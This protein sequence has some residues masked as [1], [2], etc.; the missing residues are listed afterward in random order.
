MP[1]LAAQERCSTTHDALRL[2]NWQHGSLRL[3]LCLAGGA[4]AC[5]VCRK[6]AY[7]CKVLPAVACVQQMG[8]DASALAAGATLGSERPLVFSAWAFANS[9]SRCNLP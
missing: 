9:M 1:L 2:Q 4:C 7:A 8:C 6:A 3:S 5:A